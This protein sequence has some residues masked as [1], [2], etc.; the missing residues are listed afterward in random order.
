[1]SRVQLIIPQHK[2][3]RNLL[4]RIIYYAGNTDFHNSREV[5][6][7]KTL[8]HEFGVLYADHHFTEHTYILKMA[9]ARK[10]PGEN[11][12]AEIFE[13]VNSILKMLTGK[14][15]QL[16]FSDEETQLDFYHE[17]IGFEE[18]FQNY[19]RMQEQMSEAQLQYDYSHD[20]LRV[21]LEL[22]FKRMT[23]PVLVLWCRYMMSALTA[24]D[25]A[26]HMS[27]IMK[28]RHKTS[29]DNIVRILQGEIYPERFADIMKRVKV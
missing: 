19:M 10:E 3:L 5:Q 18:V 28:T 22:N 13:S 15:G 8:I 9:G 25:A 27:A 7:F 24:T 11:F 20:E 17:L 2:A 26:V 1:M 6:Y 23:E 16:D 21:Q 14:V 4:S 12:D 29:Y